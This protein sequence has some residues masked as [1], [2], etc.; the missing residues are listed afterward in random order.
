VLARR[1]PSGS[2]TKKATT[3]RYPATVEG[4]HPWSVPN[5][6]CSNRARL[7][8]GSERRATRT[9]VANAAHRANASAASAQSPRTVTDR[10]R[11]RPLTG[12]APNA[13][14]TSHTPGRR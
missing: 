2:A 11:Q 6:V 9:T 10:C 3:E 4:R 8:A 1:R 14:R 5:H 7:T 13:T 12:S